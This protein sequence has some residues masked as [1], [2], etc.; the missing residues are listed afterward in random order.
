[1]GMVSRSYHQHKILQA[2]VTIN[3][4]EGRVARLEAQLKMSKTEVGRLAGELHAIGAGKTKVFSA[5]RKG[6]PKVY[7]V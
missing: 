2:G 4:L 7:L 3:T 5:D 1:M 6:N